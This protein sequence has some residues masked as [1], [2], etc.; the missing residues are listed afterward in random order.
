MD[1]DKVLE[2]ILG[3]I[4]EVEMEQVIIDWAMTISEICYTERPRM[5]DG[6]W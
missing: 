5:E 4:A 1:W 6:I 2:D 3:E